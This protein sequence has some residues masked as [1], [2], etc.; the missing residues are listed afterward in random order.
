MVL[1]VEAAAHRR[2]TILRLSGR[3]QSEHVD[4][5]RTQI[6]ASAKPVVLDLE[7][8]KLVDYASV[9]FLAEC[10][11]GG[12]ELSHCSPYIRNWISREKANRRGDS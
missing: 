10:E 1:R 11:A 4:Q 7:G 2:L 12:V 5:L 3:L 6:E 9:C 8:L